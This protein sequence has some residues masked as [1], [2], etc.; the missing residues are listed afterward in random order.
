[1]AAARCHHLSQSFKLVTKRAGMAS[2]LHLVFSL[3]EK[4][5]KISAPALYPAAPIDSVSAAVRA[6]ALGLGQEVRRRLAAAT[7]RLI[8]LELKR[9][10][11]GS[12]ARHARTG[13]NMYYSM[14]QCGPPRPVQ[15]LN[16]IKQKLWGGKNKKL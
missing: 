16:K 10:Q 15:K 13:I 6:K 4:E 3:L 7:S 9:L 8:R 12:E 11:P 2:P 5:K 14:S 1:M